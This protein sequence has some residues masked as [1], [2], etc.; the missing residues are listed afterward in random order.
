VFEYFWR[1][2]NIRLRVHKQSSQLQ[3]QQIEVGC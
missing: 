1:I 3:T 2:I